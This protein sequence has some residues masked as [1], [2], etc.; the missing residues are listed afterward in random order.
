[1]HADLHYTIFF[2]LHA[3]DDLQT[4]LD[5]ARNPDDK[6]L[7]PLGS[8]R[9]ELPWLSDPESNAWAWKPKAG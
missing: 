5:K 8:R 6:T 7:I 3:V 9:W 1:L 4:Y 2:M